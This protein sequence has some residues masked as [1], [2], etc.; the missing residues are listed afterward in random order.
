MRQNANQTEN[1][2]AMDL[3]LLNTLVATTGAFAICFVSPAVVYFLTAN[4]DIQ[5]FTSGNIK[6]FLVYF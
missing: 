3:K 2:N 4:K 6:Y 1:D 5:T